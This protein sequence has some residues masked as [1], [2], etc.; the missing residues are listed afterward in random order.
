MASNTTKG[1]ASALLAALF[2][3]SFLLPWKA[4]TRYGDPAL[5]VLVLLT[6]AATFNTLASIF[7]PKRPSDGQLPLRP[8]LLVAVA[9]AMLTLLGNLASAEAIYRISGPLLAVLQRCEVILVTLLGAVVLGERVRPSFWLGTALAIIGLVM[10]HA[11]HRA[12]VGA[13]DP[14]GVLFGLGC[15]ACFGSMIV[16]V[17]RYITRVRIVLL[18]T[19]RL[20]MSVALWFVLHRRIPDAS[21]LPLQLVGYGALAG[22]FGPFMSRMATIVSSRYVPANITALTALATP[23]L[24]L[25]LSFVVLGALPTRNEL[26]G[27]AIVLA[28]ISIPVTAALRR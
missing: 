17:R 7:E 1:I 22:M 26:L 14:V 20:W 28:G 19:V 16:L 2:A 3:A 23:P 12:S 11:P 25:V 27:G 10:L 6:S 8:T 5:L 15:A 4:A 24:T 13:V 9:F 18:N 21:E